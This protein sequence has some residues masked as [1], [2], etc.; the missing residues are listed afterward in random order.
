MHANTGYGFGQAHAEGLD[1]RRFRG[2][3]DSI[4]EGLMAVLLAV[5]IAGAFVHEWR[6]SAGPIDSIAH[7][8]TARATPRG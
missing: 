5:G 8:H 4:T 6:P 7:H 3:L 2:S 1:R